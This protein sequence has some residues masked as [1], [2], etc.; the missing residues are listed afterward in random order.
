MKIDNIQLTS[1]QEWKVTETIEVQKT[2]PLDTVIS[3]RFQNNK[4]LKVELQTLV[5]QKKQKEIW[6]IQNEVWVKEQDS[7]PIE[8]R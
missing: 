7:V 4:E 3:G 8:K 6:A 1:L 2:G 5:D